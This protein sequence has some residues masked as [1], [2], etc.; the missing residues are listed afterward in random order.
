MS[1]QASIPIAHATLIKILDG[2]VREATL[3]HDL[4]GGNYPFTGV[5]APRFG[6]YDHDAIAHMGQRLTALRADLAHAALKAEEAGTR[7]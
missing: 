2:L 3:C 6:S 4:A 7:A 1:N 5:T